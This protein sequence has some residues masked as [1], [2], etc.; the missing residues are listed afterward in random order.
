MPFSFTSYVY[1]DA[2][3]I[4]GADTSDSVHL[5]GVQ[6]GHNTITFNSDNGAAMAM[7]T[8]SRGTS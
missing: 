6:A 8:T 5:N 3:D 7:P 2:H 1:G 4:H